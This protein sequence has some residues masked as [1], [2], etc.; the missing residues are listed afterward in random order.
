MKI[1]SWNVAGLRAMLKK[2]NL[3][4]LLKTENF[5]IV[6]LQETKA[7][8]CQVNLPLEIREKY[9]YQYWNS[10]KGTTQRKG[11]SGTAI[12]CKFK[13][14]KRIPG[15]KID[16]EGRI[17]SLEFEKFI[18]VC[19]YTPN[20]QNLES[21]RFKFRIEQWDPEFRNYVNSIEK[22]FNKTVI[23][24]G[25]LNVAHL[26][27]DI[28]NP[29]S[30]KNKA[31]GFFDDEREQFQEHINSGFIDVFRHFYPDKTG[32]YTYWNQLNPKTRQNNKGWRIDYF[33]VKE[34]P[35]HSKIKVN[36]CN[37]LPEIYGSDHCPLYLILE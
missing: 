9:P 6:C 24:A 1:L 37:M 5:D 32:A 12:W 27:I 35:V 36:N 11:L 18:L 17:V 33:L 28:H 13:P 19:V 26:D 7:E 3:Q 31:A 34:D 2:E 21:P 22:K 29:K 8:E 23:I 20:S 10:T 25:D 14:L 16:E 30:N 15:P 4:E